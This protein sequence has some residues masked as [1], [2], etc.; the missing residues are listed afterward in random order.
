M[1]N[2][3]ASTLAQLAKLLI[4]VDEDPSPQFFENDNLEIK[5]Y[6]KLS[7]SKDL[8]NLKIELNIFSNVSEISFLSPM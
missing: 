2:L 1:S 4:R 3:Y 8:F 7:L 6:P 5:S